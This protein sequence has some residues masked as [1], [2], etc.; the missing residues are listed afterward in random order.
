MPIPK[1]R[2]R[3]SGSGI[4]A[5]KLEEWGIEVHRGLGGTGVVGTLKGGGSASG[6][7]KSIALRA[8]MDALNMQEQNDF[9]HAS[10]IPGQDAWL[11]PRRP[12]HHAAGSRQV[13]GR[14]AQFRRHG[15]FHLPAGRGRQGRRPEDGRGRPVRPVSGE[16]SLR[17]A[18]LAGNAGRHHRGPH[19][20]D[21]GGGGPVRH[22]GAATAPMAP[23]LT[24]ASTRCWSAPIS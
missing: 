1:R 14:N 6:I 7:N 13:P 5:A 2:S 15:P 11:R 17:H 10:K 4:V 18:Q 22:Q 16:R 21:H 9:P 19:R 24:S 20:S 12:H 23:C 3:S 8:D